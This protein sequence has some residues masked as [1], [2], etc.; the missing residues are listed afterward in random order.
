MELSPLDLARRVFTMQIIA[1]ALVAGLVGFAGVAIV[2]QLNQADVGQ[3]APNR[4]LPILTLVAA[5]MLLTEGT[6]GLLLPSVILRSILQKIAA[7][8][9]NPEGSERRPDWANDDVKLLAARQTAL[10]IG[11]ALLEGAGMMACIAYLLEGNLLTLG[12]VAVIVGLMLWRFP[13]VG[14]VRYWLERER[15]ALDEAKRT[16]KAN[17]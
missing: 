6:L 1:G 14:G 2:M 9:W 7:G 10:I 5:I 11:L 16:R 12:M 15:V 4:A 3:G 8:T 13:T 17:S